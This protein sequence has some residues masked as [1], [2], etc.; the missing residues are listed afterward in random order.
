MTNKGSEDV[1]LI[2]NERTLVIA[3][4]AMESHDDH[5]IERACK[6]LQEIKDDPHAV[7]TIMQ[8]GKVSRVADSKTEPT[9]YTKEEVDRAIENMT[10]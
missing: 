6:L 1:K 4:E 8:P 9:K 7:V 10:T 3:I 2:I 5:D